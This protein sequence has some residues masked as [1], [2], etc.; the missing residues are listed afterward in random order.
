MPIEAKLVLDAAISTDWAIDAS[1]LAFILDVIQ[2][3]NEAPDNI[4]SKYEAVAAKQGTL[5]DGAKRLR[6][7]GSVA[8]LPVYGPIVRRADLFSDISALASVESIAAD[9]DIARR[10]PSIRAILLDFDSPG[11]D[12]NGINELAQIIA[13][14]NLEKPV[15]VYANH[16]LASA[17]YWLAAAA[18]HIVVNPTSVVGSIGIVGL[19]RNNQRAGVIEFVSSRAPKKRADINTEAGRAQVQAHVDALEDEFIFD[20]AMY[21]GTTPQDVIDNF[22][23]G[24]TL[25]G[26]A[27]VK[28]GMADSLGTYEGTLKLLAELDTGQRAPRKRAPRVEAYDETLANITATEREGERMPN[29]LIES[30][31]AMIAAEEAEAAGG[32]QQGAQSGAQ[33]SSAAGTAAADAAAAA[34]ASAAAAT[35]VPGAQAAAPDQALLTR[36][37]TAECAA[38]VVE[39]RDAGRMA[40]AEVAAFTRAYV[41]TALL[42][43]AHPMAAGQPTGVDDLKATITVRPVNP[44][45]KAG[46]EMMPGGAAQ[47]GT[48]GAQAAGGA[49]GAATGAQ[50]GAGG[51]QQGGGAHVVP[52][53]HGG[54]AE[55]L[56]EERKAHL[57]GLSYVGQQAAA[58]QQAR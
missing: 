45:L 43:A 24:G 44:L 55:G 48:A 17:A 58:Q 6:R 39:Q 8:T 20:V 38:F 56:T 32:Q 13:S 29:K 40:P 33:G 27:A 10:D 14:I 3:E 23:Q 49:S 47:A 46:A 11:G 21:R 42:D 22:G 5:V 30:L 51:Q 53:D 50:A 2:R 37:V 16:M 52:A 31:K 36:A 4:Q 34:A 18:D 41:R 35:M 19:M 57:L 28:I 25:L 26:R 9:L 7:R 15:W 12:V 1:W 54:Q